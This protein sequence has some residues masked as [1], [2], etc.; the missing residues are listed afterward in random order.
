MRAAII[1]EFGGPDVLRV[2]AVRVPQPGPDAVRIAVRG[3]GLNHLDLFARRGLP[4]V[5]LPHIGGSDI[6]GVVDALGPGV[7]AW[8][9][10][11]PV[12]VNP[13]LSCGHCEWC[14]R[15]E[16]PL[17]AEFRIIG[18]HLDGG[19]AEY[20]VVPAAN[21]YRVPD[22]W[23]L[24]R[25]AAVPLVF[26]TAWR[27]LVTRARLVAG[28][29]LL[30]TGASGGVATAAIGVAK[31]LGARVAAITSTEHVERVR[32]LGADAVFDRRDAAHRKALHDWTGR[33]GVDVVFDA[34][35]QA[36]WHD[37]LRAVR[38]GGR[39]VVYGATTGPEAVTD[40]RFVFW[41]QIEIVGTTMSNRREFET[42]MD[43]VFGG[44]L[45]PV[46]DVVWPLERVRA[47][48]ERLEHG[49]QFGKIVLVP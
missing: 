29:T 8:K 10:G 49:D 6:A 3:S 48:H 20:V 38:R 36:T 25:A 12:V 34:V 47:A 1:R 42:V 21:L 26:L 17:C 30:I 14:L 9:P 11:D 16:D 15:G 22:A 37:N 33:R 13:T 28:E 18:E 23:D 46:I 7:H 32:A 39:F 43:L 35:G 31:H 5:P 44:L 4:G 27:G 19:F 41:K 40:V 24:M 2:E 45:Q